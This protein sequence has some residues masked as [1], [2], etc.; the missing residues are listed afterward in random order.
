MV[1]VSCRHQ[2]RIT[3]CDVVG[4]STTV[5]VVDRSTTLST[6]KRTC[7]SRKLMVE[8]LS[9]AI[10]GAPPLADALTTDKV[11]T[12]FDEN[13]SME[14]DAKYTMP[15]WR[16]CYDLRVECLNLSPEQEEESQWRRLLR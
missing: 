10:L 5:R 7:S 12:C 14:T 9:D 1:C 13:A 8:D 4:D 3:K 6:R 15:V 2:A 16:N 11:N